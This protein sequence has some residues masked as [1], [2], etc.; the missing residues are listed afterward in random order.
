M[1][2]EIIF[3]PYFE[4][5]ACY[6]LDSRLLPGREVQSQSD[7]CPCEC[8]LFSYNGFILFLFS[9]TA[10]SLLVLNSLKF[11]DVALFWFMVNT[12]VL[13]IWNL[14]P[15]LWEIFLE[16]VRLLFSPF[17][18]L[19]SYFLNWSTHLLFNFSSIGF[20]L[21]FSEIPQL[22]LPVVFSRR[23]LISKQFLNWFLIIDL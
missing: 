20:L 19:S 14:C 11:H 15:F 22:Y 5:I 18:F 2:L 21:Y 12:W 23:R 10:R 9:V 16:L 1:G 3:L 13:S 7:T 6:L 4:G 8:D 17:Y